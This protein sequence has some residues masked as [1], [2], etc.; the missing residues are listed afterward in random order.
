[1]CY[2]IKPYITNKLIALLRTSLNLTN[3]KCKLQ[4]LL[5]TLPVNE[6]LQMHFKNTIQ[7]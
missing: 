3:E 7:T 6:T 2:E 1:M 5:R 4:M